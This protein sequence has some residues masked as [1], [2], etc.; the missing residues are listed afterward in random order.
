MYIRYDR[1][2]DPYSLQFLP[3]HPWGP[4]S[5]EVLSTLHPDLLFIANKLANVY[6]VSA[7]S[8]YR[9]KEEQTEYYNKGTG[10]SWPTSNHNVRP[11]LA[12]D[13]IPWPTQYDSIPH[14]DMMLG[15]VEAIAAEQRI[16][17][18]LGKHFSYRQDYP[19]IELQ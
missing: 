14:F 1:A 4:K 7:I 6:N 3:L 18:R 12:L 17:I 19:H 13:I 10:V 5:A 8:G 16:A 9:G 2:K 15:A 11:S